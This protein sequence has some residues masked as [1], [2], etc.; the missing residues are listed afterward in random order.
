MKSMH[1]WRKASKSSGASLWVDEI[2]A[3]SV[4]GCSWSALVGGGR[5]RWVPRPSIV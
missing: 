5:R 2:V 3:V 1:F 4:I